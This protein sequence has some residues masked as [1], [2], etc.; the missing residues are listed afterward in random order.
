MEI[1]KLLMENTSGQ[2]NEKVKLKW[3]KGEILKSYQT[4]T[5]LTL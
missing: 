3:Q 2:N 4:S 5:T 1:R